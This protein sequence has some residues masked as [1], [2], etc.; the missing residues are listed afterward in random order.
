MTFFNR[1]L[2]NRTLFNRT[3]AL[4]CAASFA[5]SV[6]GAEAPAGQETHRPPFAYADIHV[7]DPASWQIG[8]AGNPFD[9]A[10]KQ[11]QAA[12]IRDRLT[13]NSGGTWFVF[14]EMMEEWMAANVAS[15][16]VYYDLGYE[17]MPSQYNRDMS[18]AIT[19]KPGVKPTALI[20]LLGL[21]EEKQ[22]PGLY[23]FHDEEAGSIIRL[24]ARGAEWSLAYFSYWLEEEGEELAPLPAPMAVAPAVA[25]QPGAP[26]GLVTLSYWWN[27]V[28]PMKDPTVA[29]EISPDQANLPELLQE[30][31]WHP[32]LNEVM[33]EGAWSP[34]GTGVL[35]ETVIR[36]PTDWLAAR[37]QHESKVVDLDAL[38]ALPGSVVGVVAV[39]F[40][41][42]AEQRRMT[43]PGGKYFWSNLL[44]FMD[45][46][47]D[48]GTF[49]N[50]IS[51]FFT[52]VDGESRLIFALD[53]QDALT[54]TVDVGLSPFA[55]NLVAGYLAKT[56]EFKPV[57]DLGT[58]WIMEENGVRLEIQRNG[59]RWSATTDTRG[60][61]WLEL[62][63]D[64]TFADTLMAPLSFDHLP[65]QCQAVSLVDS[66]EFTKGFVNLYGR[67]AVMTENAP[68]QELMTKNMP[69]L[70]ELR[71]QAQGTS[72]MA[73]VTLDPVG[74]RMG[75]FGPMGDPSLWLFSA[76]FSSIFE[77]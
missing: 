70:N 64:K 74:Y 11:P 12:M 21:Q 71:E 24:N 31:A 61:R 23:V 7:R 22:T 40:D 72:Q 37:E 75:G 4:M 13:Q 17:F 49:Q 16:H 77:Y 48:P 25:R 36:L 9:R 19:P 26:D 28:D 8:V 50:N 46:M 6:F 1:G 2:F 68:L 54:L 3:V 43:V 76:E 44:W 52:F 5:A 73:W 42:A 67:W 10:L 39:S 33:I 41:S 65:A 51:M 60:L 69:L 57:G 20:Q 58:T 55:S 32:K 34:H 38:K 63:T 29:A 30:N 27:T 15:W 66:A 45:S 18:F 14:P 59:S 56:S 35:G 62:P 53:D 47:G